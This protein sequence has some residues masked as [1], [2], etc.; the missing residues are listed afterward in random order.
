MADSG[1][2][3]PGGAVEF[4]GSGVCFDVPFSHTLCLLVTM[5]CMMT[6]MQSNQN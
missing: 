1:I 3:K 2:S 6:T 5:V 4:L